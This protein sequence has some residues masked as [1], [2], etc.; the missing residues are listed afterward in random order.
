[1]SF[2]V[3]P[4]GVRAHI[5]VIEIGGCAF[6]DFS[7]VL[8]DISLWLILGKE[9]PPDSSQG[10]TVPVYRVGDESR[11]R[12]VRLAEVDNRI[13]SSLK[14]EL[15]RAVW[16]DV[17]LL[18]PPQSSSLKPSPYIPL[19]HSFINLIRVPEHIVNEPQFEHQPSV[20]NAGT[21]WTG[22]PPME[23]TFSPSPGLWLILQIGRCV[24]AGADPSHSATSDD[25]ESP[26]SDTHAS[27]LWANIVRCDPYNQGL[28][29]EETD[30]F[31]HDCSVHHILSWPALTRSF[32]VDVVET[33]FEIYPIRTT[34]CL[35][36]FTQTLEP[37]GSLTLAKLELTSTLRFM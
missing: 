5:P 6:G 25:P 35:L 18:S 7:W 23:I 10:I 17:Y 29:D 2:T 3:T 34:S 15:R 28:L 12:Q 36:G 9:M 19:N 14:P 4:Y 27:P 31:V 1:M 16:R 32:E 24:A 11:G 13:L 8:D 26:S 33:P 20:A 22:H 21:A 37:V 30:E